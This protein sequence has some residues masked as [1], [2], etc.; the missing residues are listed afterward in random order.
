MIPESQLKEIKV[1]LDKSENPLILF[2]DDP[3]GICSY[4]LLKRYMDKGK[5]VVVKSSPKLT[6]K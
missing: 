6:E 2:D 4:L 5:G 3:D 1:A